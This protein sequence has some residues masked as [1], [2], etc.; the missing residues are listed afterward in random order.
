M[1]KEFY[2]L[3]DQIF[4]KRFLS[5]RQKKILLKSLNKQQIVTLN[6][7]LQKIWLLKISNKNNKKLQ[8]KFKKNKKI[9]RSLK[10]KKFCNGR[11]KTI[12]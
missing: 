10:Q 9:V 7:I 12:K 11:Q 8:N 2:N 4:Q 3:I 5:Q 1:E 6:K